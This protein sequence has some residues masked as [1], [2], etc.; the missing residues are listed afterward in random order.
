MSHGGGVKMWSRRAGRLTFVTKLLWLHYP[1]PR[2]RRYTTSN[3][4]FTVFHWNVLASYLGKNTNPWFLHGIGIDAMKRSQVFEAYYSRDE[5]TH[6]LKN[7]GWPSFA[8]NILTD[9]EIHEVEEVDAKL[10]S[11][12]KRLA[13]IK[14]IVSSHGAD[15]I[16]LV[17]LD[18]F[19]E[20]R[21]HLAQQ[22]YA[23][24]FVGRPRLVSKDGCGI[25]WRRSEFN[26]I[27]SS[28][29]I[30]IDKYNPDPKKD[31]CALLVMLHHRP[32]D[33][34]VVV[35]STHLARD[36]LNKAPR[37]AIRARQM[38]ELAAHI[39]E[40]I[41]ESKRP[42]VLDCPVII[43]G[44][45]NADSMAKLTGL[46]Q[47]S[48][49]MASPSTAR[50]L[51]PF[52]F[53]SK[54]VDTRGATS[55]TEAREARVDAILYTAALADAQGLSLL[56]RLEDEKKAIIPNEIIPSDH[57]PLLAQV[58]ILTH[59]A[60]LTRALR[61]WWNVV[62]P[63]SR[64]SRSQIEKQ[65][66]DDDPWK[67]DSQL[68]SKELAVAFERLDINGNG[69]IDFDE[70]VASLARLDLLRSYSTQGKKD[71]LKEHLFSKARDPERGLDF[72]DFC[73]V[74]FL[75][76]PVCERC[77]NVAFDHI[78]S[79][80]KNEYLTQEE[81]TIFFKPFEQSPL[82]ASAADFFAD[83]K[84][85]G[86]LNENGMSRESFKTILGARFVEAMFEDEYL[87][88]S[89]VAR[90]GAAARM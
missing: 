87:R 30:F 21:K 69:V 82:E 25:F 19:E 24:A 12:P 54:A 56:E 77:A 17:E 53:A 59:A 72:V 37:D 39:R 49:L 57:F 80:P 16:S 89:I 13:M 18:A 46:V 68:D 52:I 36:V 40:F 26:L 74:Y 70:A 83:A 78:D 55:R 2:I 71:V 79:A 63:M 60:R 7:P 67:T 3:V 51:H 31:R 8:R 22:G 23:G 66:F 9:T 1:E 86:L 85:R 11:W 61:K 27:N 10:F 65:I 5:T 15:I 42:I 58:G 4:T 34:N 47:V 45:V 29:L 73:A 81:L 44:D 50:K 76:H 62:L 88:Q 38:G 48:A 6:Q 64:R 75:T 41:R 90:M 14:Q 33:V 32:T 84:N 43:C 35:A 28:E 20:M